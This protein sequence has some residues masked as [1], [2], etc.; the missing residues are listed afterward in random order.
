LVYLLQQRIVTDIR[1]WVD[2]TRA[3]RGVKRNQRENQQQNGKH[4]SN[5]PSQGEHGKPSSGSIQL[6]RAGRQ[7]L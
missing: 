1:S 5:S 6:L 3:R 2:R 4:S 7:T